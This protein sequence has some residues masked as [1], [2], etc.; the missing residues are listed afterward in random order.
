VLQLLILLRLLRWIG[1]GRFTPSYRAFTFGIT[2]LATAP[3]KLLARG[4]SG[5]IADLAGILFGAANLAV[6]AFMIGTVLLAMRGKL[7]AKTVTFPL[8]AHR[9]RARVAPTG[10]NGR[11]AEHT[12]GFIPA[13]WGLWHAIDPGAFDVK[14]VPTALRASRTAVP[15]RGTRGTPTSSPE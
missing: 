12:K 15:E 7:F 2:A 5:A 6:A 9:S 10:R 8:L 4:D 13:L 1:A 11:D 14:N 3:L